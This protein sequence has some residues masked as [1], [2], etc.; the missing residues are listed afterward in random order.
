ML[1]TAF[2]WFALSI[3]VNAA[4]YFSFAQGGGVQSSGSVVQAYSNLINIT[5]P[6]C[7]ASVL[8]FNGSGNAYMVLSYN[9]DVAA[10]TYLVGYMDDNEPIYVTIY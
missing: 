10:G 9:T 3:G 2:L 1:A 8:W 4:E 6:D 5:D 7:S